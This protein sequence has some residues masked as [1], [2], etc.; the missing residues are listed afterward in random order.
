MGFKVLVN[1]ANFQSEKQSISLATGIKGNQT[2]PIANN[3]GKASAR[4]QNSEDLF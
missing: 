1:F 3:A 4:S 2:D